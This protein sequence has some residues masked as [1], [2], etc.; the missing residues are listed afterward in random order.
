MLADRGCPIGEPRIV[1]AA[2]TA[3]SG[4]VADRLTMDGRVAQGRP[5]RTGRRGHNMA[6]AR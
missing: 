2:T 6:G 1:D 3:T 4:P 5:G